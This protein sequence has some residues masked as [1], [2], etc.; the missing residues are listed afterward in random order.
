MA[1]DETLA[2]RIRE[3]LASSQ[4]VT[5]KRMFGGI[6]FLRHGLMLVGVSGTSLMA[7]VGPANYKDSLQRTHTRKMDFTGKPMNGYV[8][9]S[10]AALQTK[11][12][13]RFWLERCEDFVATL[14]S[15]PPK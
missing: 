8:Y 10:E 2:Q 11:D 13:L 3:A 9:V 14:P 12:D 4:G 7:R 15:K 5:E 6:A 1:Y